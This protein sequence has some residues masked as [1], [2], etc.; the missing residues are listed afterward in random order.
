VTPSKMKI[1]GALICF[2]K[3]KNVWKILVGKFEGK[4]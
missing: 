4:R 3:M 1:G 2:G